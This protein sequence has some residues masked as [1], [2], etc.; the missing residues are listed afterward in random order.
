L[1]AR[2][3]SFGVSLPEI[4]SALRLRATAGPRH[5]P[6]VVNIDAFELAAG[7]RGN[8]YRAALAEATGVNTFPQLFVDGEFFGG[9][10]DA[11][12]GWKKGTLQPVLE[13]AGLKAR[14][15]WSAGLLVCRSVGLSVCRSVDLLVCRSVGLLV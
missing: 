15:T 4:G 6:K 3:R 9:A 5:R 10:V 11:C 12:L 14:G 1:A 2:P 8:R 13:K 7:N